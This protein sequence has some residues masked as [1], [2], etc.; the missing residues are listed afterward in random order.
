MKR[1]KEFLPATK[2][3][4]YHNL[5]DRLMLAS[6]IFNGGAEKIPSIHTIFWDKKGIEAYMMELSGGESGKIIKNGE[7][8]LGRI[9]AEKARLNEI[10]RQFENYKVNRVN[11]GFE[12]PQSLPIDL[13]NEYYETHARLTVYESELEEL[14]KHLS[15]YV[16]EEEAKDD[17]KVLQWGLR[18]FS[19]LKNG[20]CEEIDGQKCDFIGDV[21]CIVKSPIYAGLSL[22]DYRKLSKNWLLERE[23]YARKKLLRIQQEQKLAGKPIPEQLPASSM[24][25]VN[26]SSLPKF[27]EWAINHLINIESDSST[28]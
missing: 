25:R 10:A 26:I 8:M 20:I 6:K 23:D 5:V 17:D 27:P 4:K 1:N 14:T 21:L 2:F 24:K 7:V 18:G 19:H 3:P 16:D 11:Q 13:Q 9:P 12:E 15:E 22:P 28:N